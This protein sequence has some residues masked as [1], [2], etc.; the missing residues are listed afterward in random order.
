[1]SST[2]FSLSTNDQQRYSMQSGSNPELLGTLHM[3]G[4]QNRD[5][6]SSEVVA[7]LEKPGIQQVIILYNHGL[8]DRF[9]SY[10]KIQEEPT[11][12]SLTKNEG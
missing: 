9:T 3:S 2:Q 12:L 4:P 1:M 5:Q 6:V 11:H 8:G 10:S 7:L